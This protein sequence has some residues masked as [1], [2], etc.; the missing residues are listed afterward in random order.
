MAPVRMIS[1]PGAGSPGTGHSSRPAGPSCLLQFAFGWLTFAPSTQAGLFPIAPGRRG[2]KCRPESK[3]LPV[4]HRR[5]SQKEKSCCPVSPS[6]TQVKAFPLVWSCSQRILGSMT[7]MFH[8]SLPS[9]K[10]RTWT[11]LVVLWLRVLLLMQ[12]IRVQSLVQE[13]PTCHGKTKPVHHSY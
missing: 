13:D 11:S 2:L 7:E 10:G 8:F 12:K 9:N 3:R 4:S 1:L 6:F 5:H